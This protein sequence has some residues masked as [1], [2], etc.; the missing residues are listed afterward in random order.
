MLRTSE[1]ETEILLGNKQLLG[2]FF[3]ITV[4]L[5]IAFTGGYMVGRGSGEKKSPA[6]AASVG[7]AAPS[8][9]AAGGETHSVAAAP[10]AEDTQAP[11]TPAVKNGAAVED[12]APLGA[13]KRSK[14]QTEQPTASADTSGHFVPEA[15]QTFLQVA[16]T[17]RDEAEGVAD[18]LHKRGF[19][20]HAVPKPGNPKLYRVLI[21]PVRDA[22]DLSTT[23]EA[24]RKTG[25]REVIVQKY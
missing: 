17:T 19:R 21:G 18:V 4:L 20:A 2:I 8:A 9:S 23:R 7:P 25:F 6:P 15:G 14:A 12:G 22:G 13:P 1:N 24:L 16:A 3:V 11:V 10:N 5:G